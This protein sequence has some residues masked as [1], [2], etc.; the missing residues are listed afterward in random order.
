MANLVSDSVV[1]G[2][3]QRL[4]GGGKRLTPRAAREGVTICAEAVDGKGVTEIA[5]VLASALAGV[6]CRATVSLGRTDPEPIIAEVVGAIRHHVAEGLPHYG[7]GA[8]H[9]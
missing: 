5:N 8:G 9:A 4:L 3:L 1:R 7:D 6:I 2:H